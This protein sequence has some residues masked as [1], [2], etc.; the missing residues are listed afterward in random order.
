MPYLVVPAEYCH[1]NDLNELLNLLVKASE[2][3]FNTQIHDTQTIYIPNS[4]YTV[5]KYH[6]FSHIRSYINKFYDNNSELIS[7]ENKSILYRTFNIPKRNGGYRTICAPKD[8]LMQQLRVL[9]ALLENHFCVLYHSCAYAYIHNRSTLNCVQRHQQ[10]HSKWF[11]KFDVSSFFDSINLQFTMHMLSL[12]VPFNEFINDS[13]LRDVLSLAFLNNAL[14]QGTPISPLISNIVMLPIDEYINNTL[15][16][17][18]SDFVYTRYADDIIVSSKSWFDRICVRQ[19]IM[20]AFNEFNAPFKL[21]HEKEKFMSSSNSNWC[22][23]LMLNKDD[24]ITIGHDT[25]K[26]FKS[27]LH[28]YI[29]DRLNGIYHDKH[30]LETLSGTIAYYKMVEPDYINYIIYRYNTKYNVDFYALLKNELRQNHV[31]YNAIV[32]YDDI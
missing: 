19:C 22:L 5:A 3:G 28:H 30:E 23:G 29:C 21:K 7:I 12:I 27:M 13:V 11:A 8:N 25:K 1:I 17:I 16:S 32:T 31:N 18:R 10:N 15:S 9:K 6:D 24:R 20:R 26:R 14:P 2:N 4:M